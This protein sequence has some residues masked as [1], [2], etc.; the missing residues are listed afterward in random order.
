MI[1]PLANRV[2]VRR[3]EPPDTSEGGIYLGA[4]ARPVSRQGRVLSLGETVFDLTVNDLVLLPEFGGTE[5]THNNEKLLIYG[6]AE[7]LAI[8]TP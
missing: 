6:A 1:Q 4:A 8:L 3:L 7:L 5:I 2:L